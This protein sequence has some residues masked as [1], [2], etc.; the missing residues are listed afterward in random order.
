MSRIGKKPIEIPE[1][2]EVTYKDRQVKVKGPKGSLERTIHP[3]VDLKIEDNVIRVEINSNDRTAD[4]F[5]GMTRALVAN[6][7]TGVS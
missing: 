6:M 5:Q 4:A 3:T 2:T 7:V 1:K